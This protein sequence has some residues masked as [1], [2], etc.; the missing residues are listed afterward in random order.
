MAISLSRSRI[1]GWMAGLRLPQRSTM[2]RAWSADDV[3]MVIVWVVALPHAAARFEHEILAPPVSNL[4]RGAIFLVAS[5]AALTELLVAALL[6]R[7]LGLVMRKALQSLVRH[8]KTQRTGHCASHPAR[9]G[10]RRTASASLTSAVKTY[11]L[12]V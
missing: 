12:P 5:A 10:F 7:V 9:K 3:I 2:G 11:T 4:S 6:A 8:W 1:T